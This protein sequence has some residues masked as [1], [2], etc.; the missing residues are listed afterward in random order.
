MK[1]SSVSCEDE[2]LGHSV[3]NIDNTNKEEEGIEDSIL[4]FLFYVYILL[5]VTELVRRLYI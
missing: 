5:I 1:M 2:Y 3:T 4:L